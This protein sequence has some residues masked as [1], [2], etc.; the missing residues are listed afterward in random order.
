MS[1][2]NEDVFNSTAP[3]YSYK[4]N[5]RI[6]SS[7]MIVISLK[8]PLKKLKIVAQNQMVVI[9][10]SNFLINYN[11]PLILNSDCSPNNSRREIFFYT[12]IKVYKI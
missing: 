4:S 1:V 11:N 12:T 2:N 8:Y 5:N 6:K 9:L 7:K 3:P 10:D